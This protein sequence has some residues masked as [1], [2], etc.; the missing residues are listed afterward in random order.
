MQVKFMG[1]EYNF[2]DVSIASARIT[3]R[4]NDTQH[5]GTVLRLCHHGACLVPQ[6]DP[7]LNEL[8]E[9][10]F[11]ELAASTSAPDAAALPQALLR[12]KHPKLGHTGSYCG[13][14][15][16]ALLCLAVANCV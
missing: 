4:T 2:G 8:Q 14:T 3:K 1:T 5:V 10:L 6:A 7:A 15:Q 16:E 12:I 11:E 13:P 9:L